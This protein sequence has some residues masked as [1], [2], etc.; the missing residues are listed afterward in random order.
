MSPVPVE[1]PEELAEEQEQA[2]EPEAEPEAEPPAE[3]HPE[4]QAEPQAALVGTRLR[5]PDGDEARQEAISAASSA[6]Q[7]GEL[8]VLPTD[9][10]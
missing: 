5:H 7:R 1:E 9:T 2:A 8:V 4:P 6:V 3:P 10:V